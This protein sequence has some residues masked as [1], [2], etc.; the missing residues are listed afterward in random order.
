M[1]AVSVTVNDNDAPSTGVDLSVMPPKVREDAGAGS[2]SVTAQLNG[3]AFSV[4]TTVSVSVSAGTAM[5]GDYTA[6]PT[7]FA[8]VI[9]PDTDSASGAFTL[10]PTDDV[11]DEDDE[12]VLV[13]GVATG[14][15]VT[16]AS[17]TVEDDDTRGVLVSMALVELEEDAGASSSRVYTVALSSA[18]TDAVTVTVASDNGDVT[19]SPSSLE[20]TTIN[21]AVAQAVTVSVGMD[22]DAEDDMATLT[23]MASGGDYAGET[24]MVA[25]TVDDD[26]NPSTEIGLSVAPPTVGE[27]SGAMAVVVTARLDGAAFLVDAEVSVA[28]QGGTAL[29]ADYAVSQANFTITIP[30]GEVSANGTF[31][32]TPEDDDVDED[33]ETVSVTGTATATGLTVAPATVTIEDDDARGVVVSKTLLELEEDAGASSMETYTVVLESAPTGA[34][35]VAVNSRDAALAT[36]SPP[37]LEFTTVNWVVSQTVTVSAESDVNASDGSTQVTHVV[38]GADYGANGVTASPVGVS[39]SDD[40]TA[41]SSMMLSLDRSFV[42][43]GGGPQVVTVTA[44]LGAA[45]FASPVTVTV[46]VEDGTASSSDYTASPAS[47]MIVIP[48][49]LTEANGVFTLMPTDDA[50]DEQDES[51]RVT[52]M[53]TGLSVTEVSMVIVDDDDRGLALSTGN[54]DVNE[55]DGPVTETYTV[56]LASQ[57]TAAVTVGLTVA[58]TDALTTLPIVIPTNLVFTAGNWNIPRTVTVTAP[59]DGDAVDERAT[60][61]H[62]VSGEDYGAS[63]NETLTVEVDDDETP[64]SEVAL[65]VDRASVSEDAG[66]T[67][68]VVTGALD[69]G[70]FKVARTVSVSVSAGAGTEAADFAAVADFMLAIP[71]QMLSGTATFTL[72]PTEDRLDEGNETV[73]LTGT[74]AGLRVLPVA[75]TILD[76]D[77]RGVTVTPTSLVLREGESESYTVVLETQPLGAVT[78]RV[79][80]SG[81]A[82]VSPVPGILVFTETN[83]AQAQS[84]LMMSGSDVNSDDE[85]AVVSHEVS[86]ADYEGEQAASVSVSVEDKDK[87]STEVRLTVS[88]SQ[89]GESM[90]SVQMMVTGTLDGAPLQ[91]GV[92]IA[93]TVSDGTALSGPDYTASSGVMLTIEANQA[94]G[95]VDLPMELIGD[96]QDEDDETLT[97]GGTTSGLGVVPATVT[98]EDDDTRGVTVSESSLTVVEG[99]METY[100]VV[101]ESAPTGTVTVTVSSDNREVAAQPTALVFSASDWNMARTVTV[102]VPVDEDAVDETATVTHVVRGAD[103]AGETASAVS[104]VV[105]DGDTRGVTVT[106]ASLRVPEGG[107]ETYTV[108]LTSA[109][110]G[111]V[112]VALAVTGDTDVS[113]QPSALVFTPSNWAEVRTVTVR[114]ADDADPDVDEAR[115]SHTVS[116]ADYE[117]EAAL[118]VSVLVDDDDTPSK[119]VRLKV[120]Q[121]RVGESMGSVQVVVTGTLDG[122]PRGSDTEVMLTVED[123]TAVVDEDYTAIGAT[124][125][126][127]A[128]SRS[129]TATLELTPIDDAVD[130]ADVTVLVMASTGSGLALDEMS[131]TVTIEDDDERGVTVSKSSLTVVE[132]ETETYT[133]AVS[134]NSEP[135]EAVTVK[136]SVKD[137]GVPSGLDVLPMELMFMASDWDVAQTVTVMADQYDS[138]VEY[139]ALALVE[140]EVGGADYGANSVTAEPVEVLVPGFEVEN[141]RFKVK[142]AEEDEKG[143][144][145]V[146][147]E[148][149]M[150]LKGLTV[151]FPVGLVGTIVALWAVPDEEIPESLPQGFRMSDAVVGVELLDGT[152]LPTEQTA[153]VCLATEDSRGQQVYRYDDEA[154]PPEWVALEGLSESPPEGQVCGETKYL[155]LFALGSALGDEVTRFWLA[156]FG[157]TMAR[158]VTDAVSDRLAMKAVAAT[159]WS[160]G[161]LM[162]L[163]GQ[164][165]LSGSSFVLPLAEN[166]EQRW[167]AWGQGAYTDFEGEEG[168]VALDGEV[169]TGTVGVDLERGRWLMG[170]AV[171]HSEGDGDARSAEVDEEM[172]ISLTVMHPYLRVQ[173]KDGLSLWGM[174]GYGEGDLE[175]ER[176]RGRSEVDLEMRMGVAGLRGRL[177]AWGDI[178]MALKSEV[179]AV[180]LEAEAADIPEIEADVNQARLL[181]EGVGYCLLASDKVLEA[182]AEVGA[183]YD[184]GD[185][186]KGMGV[187]VGAGLRYMDGRLTM[188]GSVRGLL[189]HEDSDYNE[190][191]VSGAM[192]LQSNRAGRGLSLRLNSSYGSTASRAEALWL[193]RDVGSFAGNQSAELG[194]SFEMELGYGLNAIGGRGILTPY[195]E[196]RRQGG[197]S[198]W[199]LGS[200]M[201]VGEMLALNFDRV[202]HRRKGSEGAHSLELRISGRW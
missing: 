27:G 75:V 67:Q 8:I 89:V 176:E 2:V 25:V 72:T 129:G 200:R 174:L 114:A 65:T 131:V 127:A 158:H 78:V 21:W 201:K 156:R 189:A 76:N 135:T 19:A 91:A 59:A 43:E 149:G 159:Q 100:E 102:S 134:L 37:S 44:S 186:E 141:G 132:G 130:G 10:T 168:G 196:F 181:L 136:M 13:A 6:S 137:V 22:A 1:A 146:S 84:V 147:G 122:A 29:S 193:R 126:I 167:M 24:A 83:W 187:D 166:N 97:V 98:I 101:L 171:S 115:I 3:A 142:I 113:A 90:G 140:H 81:D 188:Q 55:A 99:E 36:V 118:S 94:V 116:G 95:M 157:R 12:T 108:V 172:E 124:L 145:T 87:P 63:E 69:E 184:E 192:N 66:A 154:V 178:E 54:L 68:V 110:V 155:A 20:F 109:P 58:G 106:V 46:T 42:G 86:G 148:M 62:A 15:L 170:L 14:L 179:L 53:A 77:M 93:L 74:A 52:G 202:S 39:V 79:V 26:E 61:T 173:V 47:F 56:A 183:R 165:I 31:T 111:A 35:T 73:S 18:P 160:L 105:D 96:A 163:D 152:A 119:E 4:A 175:R 34:V 92:V 82:D 169:L 103:Y 162:S 70:A 190:W 117:G 23:H 197:E 48:A 60:V 198:A 128:G 40:E 153:I 125:T 199:R 64:S 45:P 57:P 133:Y 33:D 85:T 11:V 38:S 180:R 16:A 41:S 185:A 151:E 150:E 71:A 51:V 164:T 88:P 139:D 182:N 80:V 5:S 17:V 191:G 121:L 28:V 120:S 50:V 138:V 32:L 195:A 144:A 194:T 123:G 107:E 104:V 49:D 177:G 30:R 161:N 112:T 7:S 9:P 143:V